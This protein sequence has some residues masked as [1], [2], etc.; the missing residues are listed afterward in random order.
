MALKHEP[1]R[2]GGAVKAPERDGRE[3]APTVWP[4][5]LL[6]VSAIVAGIAMIA[7]GGSQLLRG[8]RTKRSRQVD[9]QRAMRDRVRED[10]EAIAAATARFR[11]DYASQAGIEVHDHVRLVDAEDADVLLLKTVQPVP[12]NTS[13]ARVPFASL[14]DAV[15][16]SALLPRYAAA[17][18]AN[19]P[20]LWQKLQP[21]S[22]DTASF[23]E[24]DQ[25]LGRLKVLLVL[26]VLRRQ[27]DFGS[28]DP[29][30]TLGRYRDWVSAALPISIDDDLHWLPEVASRCLDASDRRNWENQLKGVARDRAAIV[31]TLFL[32]DDVDAL[33]MDFD[34]ASPDE[35]ALD[36]VAWATSV[37]RTRGWPMRSPHH[38]AVVPLADLNDQRTYGDGR[39][40]LAPG[41]R[42]TAVLRFDYDASTAHLVAFDA[43]DANEYPVTRELTALPTLPA[44]VTLRRYGF[45][46]REQDTVLSHATALF[47]DNAECRRLGC[48]VGSALTFNSTSG[49]PSELLRRCTAALL[50]EPAK[51]NNFLSR[52]AARVADSFYPERLS[53]ECVSLGAKRKGSLAGDQAD[54]LIRLNDFTR[55]ALLAVSEK[56]ST[57]AFER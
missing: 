50:G 10:A 51:V 26:V 2:K 31:E 4:H 1:Q 45:A 32:V 52:H 48:H 54:A 25:A 12:A 15:M 56:L 6:V 28:E 29:H 8:Q 21:I 14:I 5:R 43:L 3:A 17:V 23:G 38:V 11:R 39:G 27:R 33:K 34:V 42:A 47:K 40:A 20:A 49:V 37:L 35:I 41:K 46:T 44:T 57:A 22:G 55:A 13:L 9:V 19:A 30:P 53:A 36:D 7:F 16:A 24:Q 18:S